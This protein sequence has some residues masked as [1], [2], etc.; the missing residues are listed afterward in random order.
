MLL[1]SCAHAVPAAALLILAASPLALGSCSGSAPEPVERAPVVVPTP[2]PTA[3][4][5]ATTAPTTTATAMATATATATAE[6]TATATAVTAAPPAPT[7]REVDEG[8]AV[9]P[10][11]P[12][13][14]RPKMAGEAALVWQTTPAP[15]NPNGPRDRDTTTTR[16]LVEKNGRAEVV[17]ERGEAVFSSKSS[18][19]HLAAQGLPVTAED[20]EYGGKRVKRV[21]HELVFASLTNKG[22]MVAPMRS[23]ILKGEWARLDLVAMAGP[24]VSATIDHYSAACYGRPFGSAYRVAVDLDAGRIRRVAVPAGALERFRPILQEVLNKGCASGSSKIGPEG[25]GFRYDRAGRLVVEHDF[26]ALT[27]PVCYHGVAHVFVGSYDLPPEVAPLAQLPAWLV[28]YLEGRPSNGVSVIAP[29]REQAAQ[30]EFER[31]PVAS[32]DLPRDSTH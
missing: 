29:G 16:Y 9:E 19:W 4:T 25:L 28:G 26:Y 30:Q 24:W 32:P 2:P 3:S 20:C 23:H 17:A 18:L 10:R 1:P 22:R 12:P 21:D 5:A 11:E 31:L 13:P 8:W 7:V 27:A 14:V 6:S 15:P